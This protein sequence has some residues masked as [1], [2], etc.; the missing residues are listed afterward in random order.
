MDL[1]YLKQ[2]G[3][4][5]EEIEEYSGSWNEKIISC[6]ADNGDVVFENMQYLKPYLDR[7]LL[8]KLPVFYDNTFTISPARF[9]AR[10]DLF[11]ESFPD[12]WLD[13][14]KK[15]FYGYSGIYGSNYKPIMSMAGSDN[16]SDMV[17]AIEQLKY[18][19]N[20]VFEFM[21]L[22]QEV[23]IDVSADDF[24]ENCLLDLEVGKHEILENVK[25]LLDAGLNTDLMKNLLCE[26]PYLMLLSE[27]EVKEILIERFGENYIEEMQE[28]DCDTLVEILEDWRA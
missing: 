21:I 7:K 15:Q 6:L 24:C 13:I 11:R 20:T 10:M 8:L 27:M 16:D 3:Y 4:T 14:I 28:M 5:T 2:M 22:L 1:S 17:E 25:T 18:P 23:E 9:K 12:D 19:E 26:C